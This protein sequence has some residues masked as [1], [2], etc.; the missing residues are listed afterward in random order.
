MMLVLLDHTRSRVVDQVIWRWQALRRVGVMLEASQSQ[1]CGVRK[2]M[3]K[4]N[5]MATVKRK[6]KNQVKIKAGRVQ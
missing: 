6:R 1:Q 3:R 2:W 5:K 4:I